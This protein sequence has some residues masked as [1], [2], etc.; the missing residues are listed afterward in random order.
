MDDRDERIAYLEDER[1]R[2]EVKVHN[3]EYDIVERDDRIEALEKE[4]E[5]LK[6]RLS[7]KRN[8]I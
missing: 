7:D 6:G 4:I 1:M 2:L 5:Q 3:L 8:K